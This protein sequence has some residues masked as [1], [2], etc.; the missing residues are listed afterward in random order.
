MTKIIKLIVATLHESWPNY[1][2]YTESIEQGFREPCFSIAQV[3]GNFE[4]YPNGRD[5]IRQHFDVRF[6]P[7]GRRSREQCQEVAEKLAFQLREL[8]GVRGT[9]IEWEITNDVL[10]F[11]V[12]YARFVRSGDKEE[13][14]EVLDQTQGVKNG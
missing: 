7:N 13:S 10:H 4:A 9:D 11:F 14:M 1:D 12:T 5:Y 6:F 3:E 8:P 2:I